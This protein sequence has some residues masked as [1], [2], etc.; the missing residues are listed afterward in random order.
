MF[1]ARGLGF[2]A[3]GIG[4]GDFTSHGARPTKRPTA[5]ICWKNAARKGL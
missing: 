1:W 2:R 5:A 3:Q 4:L